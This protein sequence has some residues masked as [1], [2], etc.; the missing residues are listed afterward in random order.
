MSRGKWATV[1]LHQLR[2]DQENYRLGPQATQREAIRA[3]IE[4]QGSKLVRLAKDILAMEGVSPGEPIWVVPAGVRGQ[5]IVEEGNRRVT[6]LKLLE[7]PALADGTSVSKQFR[8][9]A[10]T[11]A[12]K[13]IRELDARLFATRQDV[14]P[15]KRRRHMTAGS[16]VGLAAW[17]TL[18]KGRAN[19][20]LGLDAPRSLAVVEFFADDKSDAWAEILEALDG[21]WTTVDRVLNAGPFK[22]VLG[23]VIDP[24]TSV[25]TFENG[26]VKA[27]S[28][29]LKRLLGAMAAP[30]FEFAE[31]EDKD[32]RKAFID[33]FAGSSVKAAGSPRGT[34]ESPQTAETASEPSSEAQPTADTSPAPE[35]ASSTSATTGPVETTTSPAE[36]STTSRR[37]ATD[38][39]RKTLAPADGP[40]LLPVQGIR[41]LPLYNECRK[42]KVKGNENAAALLVRV[43]IELS[44][45]NYLQEKN[46]PMPRSLRDKHINDW[47]DYKVKLSDKIT[48]VALHI[49]PTKKAPVFVQAREAILPAAVGSFSINML[50]SYFHNRHVLPDEATIKASWDGWEAYLR[51]LYLALQTP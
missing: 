43:F 30:D 15:W 49:D 18:A 22:E 11:Y 7:T 41:L 1:K 4:D 47:E 9:L 36:T 28:D 19:R 25:I 2:L 39:N 34:T 23:I 14:L 10:K 12:E 45:E 37:D 32:D 35:G 24:K 33:K 42:L 29:L 27:G 8:R 6:A 20:D 13:P 31:I 17:K 26:D 40:R 16:G 50:H 48:C 51:E 3:M 21:R 38:A 5:Y 46:V 44:S